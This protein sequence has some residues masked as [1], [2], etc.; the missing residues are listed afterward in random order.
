MP[1]DRLGHLATRADIDRIEAQLLRL[2]EAVERL[3]KVEVQQSSHG[4]RLRNIERDLLAL[5]TRHEGNADTLN[6]WI[7][8]GLGAWA[9]AAIIFTV[10]NAGWGLK[11]LAAM[12]AQQP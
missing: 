11:F 8:R 5:E 10:V 3:V 9:V 4:E 6:K 12:A 2:A 7:N 1:E